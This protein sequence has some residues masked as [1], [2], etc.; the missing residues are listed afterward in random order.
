MEMHKMLIGGDRVASVSGNWDKVI[1]PAT[2]SAIAE[3]PQA[4][5]A[6]LVPSNGVWRP[7]LRI[8]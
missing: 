1:D 7:F 3:V 4:D 6:A 5:Y 2:E 8:L